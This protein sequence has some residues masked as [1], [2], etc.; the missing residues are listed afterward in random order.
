MKKKK[1]EFSWENL[2]RGSLTQAQFE[3]SR[4]LYMDLD[5][6]F[7]RCFVELRGDPAM[8]NQ[9]KTTLSE[10]GNRSLLTLYKKLFPEH[11]GD[12]LLFTKQHWGW[13]LPERSVSAWFREHPR[14]WDAY[15][16]P[17]NNILF[18]K[19]LRSRKYQPLTAAKVHRCFCDLVDSGKI[20]PV[21]ST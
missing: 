4:A 21:K 11:K 5:E 18:D 16:S 17:E 15:L 2:E 3:W 7:G 10:R 1:K 8:L 9:I 20:T 14:D 12:I 6:L 19:A 13:P